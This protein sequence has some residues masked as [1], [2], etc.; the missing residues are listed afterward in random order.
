MAM[1]RM[2]MARRTD[3][4]RRYLP[5]LSERD[6]ELVYYVGLCGSNSIY[7]SLKS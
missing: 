5:I 2:M 6:M 4:L 1:R 3:F 7:P